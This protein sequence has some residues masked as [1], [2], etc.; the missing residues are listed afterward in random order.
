MGLN[1]F[2]SALA[3]ID[4][5]GCTYIEHEDILAKHSIYPDRICGVAD[6]LLLGLGLL[7]GEIA[8]IKIHGWHCGV[9]RIY[10]I[11]YPPKFA[12]VYVYVQSSRTTTHACPYSTP[13][14]AAS[15]S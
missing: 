15:A 6:S 4:P 3:F 14:P 2:R 11:A 12:I 5:H 1:E 7:L 13:Q 10:N 9:D 8:M